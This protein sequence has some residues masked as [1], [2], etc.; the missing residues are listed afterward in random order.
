MRFV[1]VGASQLALVTARLLVERGH[2]GVLVEADRARIE[3]VSDTIDCGFL[4]GDGSK[5]HVLRE[6]DPAGAD[7]LFCL[8]ENDQ[9]NIIAALIGRSLG[10]KRVVPSIRDPEFLGI[11][12]ELGLDDTINP[13]QTIGRYL[14][15]MA[16]GIDIL[17]LSTIIKGEARFFS[18]TATRDEAG[19]VSDL[20]LPREARVICLYRERDFRLADPDTGIREGDEVVLLA[21]SSTLA[22]LH[23]RWPAN[24]R[25]TPSD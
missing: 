11:C 24:T 3:E 1:F 12:K 15:D 13:D 2:D 22:E 19:P 17:E 5:P 16:A 21:H 14:A 9:T 18:F 10:C 6:A 8:S 25:Q 23:E 20:Q 4:Q 7:I